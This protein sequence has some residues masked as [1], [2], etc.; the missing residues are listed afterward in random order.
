[1]I[2]CNKKDFIQQINE[3]QSVKMMI[4]GVSYSFNEI[5]I[6][7]A[8]KDK[9]SQNKVQL[10]T[11]CGGI[12]T[13]DTENINECHQDGAWLKYTCDNMQLLIA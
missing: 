3:S 7:K 4:H 6:I 1:M 13:I 5:K 10:F 2:M 12:V 11:S 8:V 9:Y